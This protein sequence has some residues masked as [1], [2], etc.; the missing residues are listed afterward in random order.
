[1]RLTWLHTNELAYGP[2]RGV[3]E[4]PWTQFRFWAVKWTLQTLETPNIVFHNS[5][6]SWVDKIEEQSDRYG[7]EVVIITIIIIHWEELKKLV[8]GF[9]RILE[10]EWWEEERIKDGILVCVE[11]LKMV[12]VCVGGERETLTLCGV[13]EDWRNEYAEMVLK[14]KLVRNLGDTVVV[15]TLV[16]GRY[17]YVRYLLLKI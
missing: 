14:W 17:T 8:C 3:R 10:L 4:V 7:E 5:W 15:M 1:M 13:C 16:L 6:R 11:L 2:N 12:C 9:F